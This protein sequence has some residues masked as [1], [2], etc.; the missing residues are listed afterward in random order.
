MKKKKDFVKLQEMY[1]EAQELMDEGV[2]P[3]RDATFTEEDFKYG[4]S[5]RYTRNWESNPNYSD[6]ERKDPDIIREFD[7]ATKI[8]AALV[9]GVFGITMGYLLREFACMWAGHAYGY[10]P[11]ENFFTGDVRRYLFEPPKPEERRTFVRIY[12]WKFF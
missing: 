7:S 5:Y 10:Y 1:E 6:W 9:V 2:E 4:S 11:P 3:L 8:K 12:F